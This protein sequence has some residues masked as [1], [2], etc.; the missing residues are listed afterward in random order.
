MAL[1]EIK[2]VKVGLENLTARIYVTQDAPLMTSDDLVATTRIYYLM[3]HIV[4][5]VCMGD[6]DESFKGVMGDT[7]I[8]HLLEHMTVEL[9]SQSSASADI[10]SGKT[11]P[12]EED[13]RSFDIEL[14]CPDDVLVMGAL[15]S[16]VWIANWAFG[17]GAE[18]APDVEAIVSGLTS[19]VQNI[20]EIHEVT[21]RQEVE[22]A[23]RAEVDAEYQRALAQREAEIAR[24]E[25]EIAEARAEVEAEARA[26]QEA[27]RL[28]AEKE[29][30]RRAQEEAD[31]RKA[32][33]PSWAVD[34]DEYEAQERLRAQEEADV[35]AAR[36]AEREKAERLEAETRAQE[37]AE[38]R[39]RQGRRDLAEQIA[40][41]QA[42]A[43]AA[44]ARVEA[45]G[46][47]T[48]QS[49]EPDA[50][51]P[52]EGAPSADGPE[53][54]DV[55]Q[56]DGSTLSDT[57]RIPAQRPGERRVS[58]DA[59]E[60]LD[61]DAEDEPYDSEFAE[62]LMHPQPPATAPSPFTQQNLVAGEVAAIRG[63]EGALQPAADEG[64][65]AGGDD[66]EED[67][68]EEDEASGDATAAAADEGDDEYDVAPEEHIPGPHRVR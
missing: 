54:P 14:S 19:M 47:A 4:E 58:A 2:R 61:A 9:L 46:D 42:A 12:V 23:L 31:E 60:G 22:D 53:P 16:A 3:P 50:T 13:E 57:A 21:Y 55:A 62:L 59:D 26:R 44:A 56:T 18:P 7:E 24:R 27:D 68:A 28:E 45:R 64:V 36:Q 8:A 32:A 15:S 52:V 34:L 6:R 41:E 29:A 5:H 43:Q 10:S 39:S 33:T 65:V 51:T 40:Q 25:A 66:A 63:D 20:G 1:F 49:D 48:R 30:R 35:E 37:E 11:Y 17:G 67:G 38:R